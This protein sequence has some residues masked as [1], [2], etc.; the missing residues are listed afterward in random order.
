[1]AFPP[2]EH[3]RFYEG[4]HDVRLNISFSNI[5]AFTLGEFHRALP[6]DLDLNWTDERGSPELRGLIA[7]R[8]GVGA[9]HVLVTT[10]ATEANFLVNAALVGRGD[11]VVVDS[12]IYSPLRDCALGFGGRVIPVP[13]DCRDGWTLDMD[14]LRKAA[15]RRAKLLVFANLNNPTSAPI[16]RSEIREFADIAEE[17]DGYVLVDE[18][19]RELAFSQPPPSVAAFGSRM[20]AISTVTKVGGLGAL[21]V[22]WIVASPR[23]LEEFKGVKDYTTICGS[24]VSEVLA[25]W[26]LKRWDFFRRRA[27]T[28]L[29]RNR[30]TVREALERMPALHGDVPTGGTVMFPHSDVPV[31]RLA[32]RLLAAYKTV[33]AEG[34]F[35]GLED[36]FRIGLGGDT[37]EL[38]R[39]L[40]SLGHALRDLG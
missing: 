15:G 20:I 36:H 40:R 24:S 8:H 22:G 16:G 30:R 18:T 9:D 39:G 23:L 3:L 35:F 6:K 38:R 27:R 12:P 2:F 7:R 32:K 21:R 25:T 13:R 5:K 14:R 33:I 28:I 4:V 17:C 26:A 1:M 31:S 19:F 10:G 37:G 11:R 29:D 34:R